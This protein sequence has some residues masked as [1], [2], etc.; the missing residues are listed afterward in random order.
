MR[1][2]AVVLLVAAL[3]VS[4]GGDGGGLFRQYE[5]EEE[6]YLSLDGS[7]TIYVNSSVAALNALRSIQTFDDKK[8]TT[9]EAMA[10]SAALGVTSN[11]DMGG[12]LIPGS[13][14]H[15]DEFTFDGAASWDPYTAYD[16]LLDLQLIDGGACPICAADEPGSPSSR[17]G[18]RG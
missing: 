11:F 9:A 12:F 2:R 13:P 16:A 3:S 1:I 17:S 6:M 5:Y 10:Y 8:R 14:D 15:E 7:A 4:C 18:L